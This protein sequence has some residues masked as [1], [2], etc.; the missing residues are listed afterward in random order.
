MRKD[1]EFRTEDGV[2][3]RGWHYVP[4]GGRGPCPTIVMAH[5]FSAVKEMYLDRFAEV[6]AAA[7]PGGARVRQPQ[8]RRQRRR[9]APGD[10]PLAAGRATTATRSPIAETL[11]ETDAGPDRHLGLELQRRPRPGGRRDRPPRQVRRRPGAADQRPSQRPP[12]DPRRHRGRRRRRHVRR[13]PARPATPASR[14]A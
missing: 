7:G 6:F 1:I 3:L 2:T 12:A 8:F 4:D 5:G 11:P 9:A 10:R 13:G 14:P